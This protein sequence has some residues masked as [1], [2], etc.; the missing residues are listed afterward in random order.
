ML[1]ARYSK[2]LTRLLTQTF[3]SPLKQRL[4]ELI[5]GQ[6]Q[7]VKKLRTEHGDKVLGQY[8]IAQVSQP[9]DININNI[10]KKN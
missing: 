9:Y 3:Q 10:Q 1:F 6:Q 4:R 5:P 8:T 7:R 2:F